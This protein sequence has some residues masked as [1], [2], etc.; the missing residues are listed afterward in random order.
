MA[1][2]KT[3][4]KKAEK[5]GFAAAFVA[6]QS[7]FPEI[8]KDSEVKTKQYTYHYASLPEIL[9]RVLPV[10][11]EHGFSLSQRFEGE[12]LVTYLEHDSG[13]SRSSYLP[14]SDAGLTPQDFGKKITYYRRY[15]IVAMLGLAPDDDLDAV[16]V[17]T[18]AG[19]PQPAAQSIGQAD[20]SLPLDESINKLA[21]RFL[22]HDTG[23]LNAWTPQ[24]TKEGMME[25][26]AALLRQISK[27][28][29]FEF[30]DKLTDTDRKELYMAARRHMSAEIDKRVA[31]QNGG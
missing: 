30:I 24:T 19:P 1:E 8:P 7:N 2:T 27:S 25:A 16:G 21:Q 26:A 6:A 13:E 9:K 14:C 29:E 20:D 28:G 22:L 3:T 15:A 12:G 4:T 10:L 11:H 17:D 31:A 5:D 23:L 18:P